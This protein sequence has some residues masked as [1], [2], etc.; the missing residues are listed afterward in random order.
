MGYVVCCRCRAT[1]KLVAVGER[2]LSTSLTTVGARGGCRSIIL[3]QSVNLL[4]G[5]VGDKNR[6]DPADVIYVNAPLYLK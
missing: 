1:C 5:T 3:H 2:L 6:P 4:N